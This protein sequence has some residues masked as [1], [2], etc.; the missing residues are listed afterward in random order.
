MRDGIEY[1]FTTVFEIGM[2]HKCTPSKDRT[3]LFTDKTFLIT[4]ETG[5]QIANW[6]QNG[7]PIMQEDD[8]EEM[9]HFLQMIHAAD[10]KDALGKI[11]Q[12]IK[13]STL[14]E[15]QKDIVRNAYRERLGS[16][17]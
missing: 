14:P 11:G 5:E 10:S 15:S 1:E 16:L 13:K 8:N 4:E 7:S 6:L 12:Q 3:K 17:A 9:D 2:D